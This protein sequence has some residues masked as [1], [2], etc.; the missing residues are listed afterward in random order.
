MLPAT[1]TPNGQLSLFQQYAQNAD[2]HAGYD[3]TKDKAPLVGVP[4]VIVGVSFRDG[5]KR[6]GPNGPVP[7]NYASVEIILGDAAAFERALR[8]GRITT[9][10]LA[11]FDANEQI[12]FNDGSTGICRQ[13]V[14]HLVDKG[15]ISVP[16][17]PVGGK[18][19]ESRFDTY[20]T[21]WTNVT[22]D[23]PDYDPADA[24]QSPHFTV[25]YLCERGLRDSE[26]ESD[27]SPDGSVT[28]YL[29]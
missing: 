10:Q 14:A 17:G 21:E 6:P 27:Y 7:T 9:E 19:G 5:V 1:T 20:R 25:A 26:Y 15:R 22:A 28:Y 12:V 29:A 2:V 23:D 18:T 11:M 3:L 24:D 13:I 16:D 4:F 8:R